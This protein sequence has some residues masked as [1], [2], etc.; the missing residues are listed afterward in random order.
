MNENPSSRLKEVAEEWREARRIYPIYSVLISRFDLPLTQCRFLDSPIDRSDEESKEYVREWLQSVDECI[1]AAQLRLVLQS[2][3]LG[4]EAAMRSLARRYL[5]KPD[6]AE[7]YRD[8]IEFLLA[9]YFSQN[10]TAGAARGIVSHDDVAQTLEPVI[11]PSNGAAPPWLKE[12]DELLRRLEKFRSLRDFLTGG[13]LEQ[14]RVLKSRYSAE[15]L[16]P[17]VLASITRYNFLVRLNFI[18]LL[19]HDLEQVQKITHS[20]AQSGVREIDGSGAGLSKK[21]TPEEVLRFAANWKAIFRKDYSERQVA[22]AVVRVLDACEQR[23]RETPEPPQ[24][25]VSAP[26]P[27]PIPAGAVAGPSPALSSAATLR[28]SPPAAAKVV[29]PPAPVVT[30]ATIQA[31]EKQLSKKPVGPAKPRFAMYEVLESI[32][33]QLSTANVQGHLATAI[34]QVGECKLTLSSWEVSA[35]LKDPIASSD[36]LQQAVVA[37]A[38]LAEAVQ[39]S[40][41]AGP[42]DDLKPAT[43]LGRGEIARLQEAIAQARDAHNI[44][45]AVN[46][47]AT[48]KRL[49]QV[50]DEATKL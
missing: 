22:T 49:L 15:F 44:D 20:L 41:S 50:L 37:R 33:A 42:V 5:A 45:S 4:T 1:E 30:P 3:A 11:G 23:L 9:Q 39:R 10:A 18:R 7:A 6:A 16:R 36:L 40:K 19:H 29:V 26:T 48:Q 24:A 25:A 35:F 17:A 2:T 13:V 46:L 27:A 21:A 14:G 12:L 28:T 8:R 34:V 43:A 32:S 47:A 38:I 31:A